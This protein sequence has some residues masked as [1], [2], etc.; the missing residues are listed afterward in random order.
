MIIDLARESPGRRTPSPTRFIPVN[1]HQ[2][3]RVIENPADY[4]LDIY[5][6][7]SGRDERVRHSVEKAKAHI[8]PLKLKS[9][10]L[11]RKSTIFQKLNSVRVLTR[12]PSPKSMK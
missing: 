1:P 10:L 6:E 2:A 9:Q 5:G 4:D 8:S 7:V 12:S 3:K 11:Q